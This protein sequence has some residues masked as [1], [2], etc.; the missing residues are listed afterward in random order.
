MSRIRTPCIGICSTTYGGDVCRGCR[1]F[2]HE[3]IGWNSYSEEQKQLVWA[4]L[5]HLVEEVAGAQL[6]VFDAGLLAQTLRALGV[7]FH[8]DRTPLFGALELL[9]ALGSQRVDLGRFGVTALQERGTPGELYRELSAEMLQRAEAWHDRLHGR[10]RRL[11][12]NW[13]EN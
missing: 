4:R 10:A 1:R 6:T 3:V 2:A 12:E 11:L 8:E 5:E 9:R 7:R 13:E